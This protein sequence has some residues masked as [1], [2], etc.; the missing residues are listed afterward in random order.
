MLTGRPSDLDSLVTAGDLA[1]LDGPLFLPGFTGWM[2]AYVEVTAAAPVTSWTTG[3]W[4]VDPYRT[5]DAIMF[6][7]NPSGGYEVEVTG[8]VAEGCFD[9]VVIDHADAFHAG[10][11]R[12]FRIFVRHPDSSETTLFADID[13]IEPSEKTVE[14][15][16]GTVGEAYLDT[17]DSV[18]VWWSDCQSSAVSL[19][20]FDARSGAQSDLWVV[21]LGLLL[22]VCGGLL[23]LRRR[24]RGGVRAQS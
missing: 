23:E 20:G 3:A 7:S 17:A 15:P 6:D 11:D 8:A 9:I 4:T 2:F 5:P 14:I 24:S 21:L 10:V 1:I 18:A 22:L 16:G 13:T 19:A 12:V